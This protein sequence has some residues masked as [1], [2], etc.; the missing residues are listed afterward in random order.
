MTGAAAN[1]TTTTAV[2]ASQMRYARKLK[3]GVL[4]TLQGDPSGLRPYF[5][6]SDMRVPQCQII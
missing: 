1:A 2:L 4:T 6:D 3:D 5:F